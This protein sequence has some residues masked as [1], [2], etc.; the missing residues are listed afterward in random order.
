[1]PLAPFLRTP[2][3]NSFVSSIKENA[4]S[5]YDDTRVGKTAPLYGLSRMLLY[6]YLAPLYDFRDGDGA[7]QQGQTDHKT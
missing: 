3:A 5:W 7:Q 1:M 6:G 4:P 2:R